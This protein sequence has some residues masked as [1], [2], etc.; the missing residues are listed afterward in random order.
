[1][2]DLVG[3]PGGLG[4]AG[5]LRVIEPPI[6]VSLVVGDTEVAANL[7]ED[8]GGLLREVLIAPNASGPLRAITHGFRLD[9]DLCLSQVAADRR[10]GG[11]LAAGRDHGHRHGDDAG[12]RDAAGRMAALAA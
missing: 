1:G 3:A 2:E 11:M 4:V 12:E 5:D 7:R 6:L 9:D 10:P 8:P